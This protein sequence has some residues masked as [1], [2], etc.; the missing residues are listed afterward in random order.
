MSTDTTQPVLGTQGRSLPI[1]EELL[2]QLTDALR[3]LCADGAD[4]LSGVE[5]DPGT[6]N[7]T[8]TQQWVEAQLTIAEAL[9]VVLAGHQQ[10]LARLA[11]QLGISDRRMGVALGMTEQGA[12]QRRKR[13]TQQQ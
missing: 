4:Q 6:A 1:P 11:K 12:A 8:D 7:G 10:Q 5:L 13:A 3:Q 9:S 2:A